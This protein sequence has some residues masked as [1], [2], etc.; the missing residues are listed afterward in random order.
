M[1][2]TDVILAFGLLFI[3]MKMPKS[4]GDQLSTIRQELHILNSKMDTL[5]KIV[6][7]IR[8]K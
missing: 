1:T 8:W 6:R 3:W 7:E 5:I 4:N 2:L